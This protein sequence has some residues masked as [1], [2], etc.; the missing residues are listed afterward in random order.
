[1]HKITVLFIKDNCIKLALTFLISPMDEENSS[2][3]LEVQQHGLFQNLSDL[4]GPNF[5]RPSAE[6]Q[7]P[8]VTW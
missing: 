5:G 1:M 7:A 6:Q 3:I 4:S 8:G 2:I